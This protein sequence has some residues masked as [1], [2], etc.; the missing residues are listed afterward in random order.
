MK[1]LL[2]IKSNISA[3]FVKIYN[4]IGDKQPIIIK[5]N[6]VWSIIFYNKN[7]IKIKN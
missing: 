7:I 4:K 3:K 1:F 2:A 5:T 6:W